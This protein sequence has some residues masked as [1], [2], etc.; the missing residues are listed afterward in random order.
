M[1]RPESEA[2]AIDRIT[3]RLLKHSRMSTKAKARKRAKQIVQSPGF[4]P[5]LVDPPPEKSGL[6][7]DLELRRVLRHAIAERIA[8]FNKELERNEP[9]EKWDRLRIKHDVESFD[10]KDMNKIL[11]LGPL[12]MR[13]GVPIKRVILLRT[14]KDPVIISRRR[15]DY[16]QQRWV[17]DTA[18]SQGP[19]HS[20]VRTRADRAYVGG[21][22]HHI[23]IREDKNCR[24]SGR[25]IP[26][27]EATRRVRSQKMDAVDRSDD[28]SKGG[29]F[30]M[31][32]SEGETVYMRHKETEEPGY[33]VVFKLDKPQKIQFKPHWDARRAKGEKDENGNLIEGSEREEIP[34]SA[35]QLKDL[36]PPGH[37]TPIKVTVDPLGCPR[38]CE[39][40][41]E[42]DDD[43]AK[44]DSRIVAIAREALE[45]RS[46]RVVTTIAESRGCAPGS[47][48]WMRSRL[49]LVG[50]DNQGRQL[51]AAVRILKSNERK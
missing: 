27:F 12:R 48:N 10:K 33:F 51:S 4:R 34:V 46:N 1:P 43:L 50:L 9:A 13:S 24:W 47:W 23:E 14:M 36:A 45:L 26:T 17:R 19:I 41:P 31:S 37:L 42:K 40:I 22:N 11:K 29:R 21:N 32:L 6:V 7:R 39:P 35:S 18:R 15:F 8:E 16:K 30:I 49:H 28:D 3:Q 44:I 20:S 2:Q 25:I 38:P 5:K